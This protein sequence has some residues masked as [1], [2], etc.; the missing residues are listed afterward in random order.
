MQTPIVTALASLDPLADREAFGD[1]AA[2]LA[3]AIGLGLAVPP[4]FA[5]GRV[6]ADETRSKA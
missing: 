5:I 4:G 2:L 3:R 1:K 6:A